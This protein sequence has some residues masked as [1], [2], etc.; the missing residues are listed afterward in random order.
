M[1]MSFKKLENIINQT[2]IDASSGHRLAGLVERAQSAGNK[3]YTFNFLVSH[4]HPESPAALAL[5]LHALAERGVVQRVLRVESPTVQGGIGEFASVGEIPQE[6]FD[7]RADQYISVDPR[8]V[9]VIY[10]VLR[11][12]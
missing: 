3:E 6:V 9:K 7:Y 8:D 10:K 4:V 12:T 2:P 5:A 1:N 11:D